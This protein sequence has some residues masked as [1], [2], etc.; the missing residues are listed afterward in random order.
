MLITLFSGVILPFVSLNW[1]PDCGDEI[2][3]RVCVHTLVPGKYYPRQKLYT[4][5]QEPADP[6]EFI[7]KLQ[8]EERERG[9]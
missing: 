7:I 8:R 4:L 5:Q 6:L 3:R 9:A 1:I 2:G